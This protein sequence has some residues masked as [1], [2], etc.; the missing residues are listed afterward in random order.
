MKSSTPLHAFVR[1][2]EHLRVEDL[3]R[4]SEVYTS[5]IL[6]SD[7]FHHV[8]GI[9]ALHG[10]FVR[11]FETFD[12]AKFT[13]LEVGETDNGALILWRFVYV[14]KGEEGHFEGTS[15]LIF[16]E[17]GKVSTHIDY[18]DASPIFEKVPLLGTLLRFVRRKIA[19]R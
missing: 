7:P 15:H 1:F 18:W 4:L 14:F 12:T 13:V 11:M 3:E 2:F 10:I 19:S 16:D 9:E 8:V 5:D 17:S 6:F